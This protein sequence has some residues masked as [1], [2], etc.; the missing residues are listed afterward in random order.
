MTVCPDA[1]DRVEREAWEALVRLLDRRAQLFV[2][3]DGVGRDARALD[4]RLSAYLPGN[5]FNQ[6]AFRPVN[7]HVSSAVSFILA[8]PSTLR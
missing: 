2:G 5:G 4:D 3:Q 1:A 8:R 6:I 7:G